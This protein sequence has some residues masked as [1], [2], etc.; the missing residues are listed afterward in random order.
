MPAFPL[1]GTGVLE[2]K[3]TVAASAV[4]TLLSQGL[5]SHRRSMVVMQCAVLSI[6]V[7]VPVCHEK[8]VNRHK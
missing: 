1:A 8:Q 4:S 2:D 5:C 6:A 7:T 3:A